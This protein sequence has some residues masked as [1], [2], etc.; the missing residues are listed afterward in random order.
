M[1]DIKFYFSELQNNFINYFFELLKEINDSNNYSKEEIEMICK[2]YKIASQAHGNTLR[3]SG[4]PYIIHPLNV[5]HILVQYGFDADTICAALLHDTVEDTSYTLDEI[6]NDFNETIS[7]LVDGVTKIKKLSKEEQEIFT[8]QKLLNSITKDA[9]VIAIKLA[10]RLHNMVTLEA[11]S[12]EKQQEN[13]RETRDFYVPLAR[14]LGIYKLKDEIQDLSLFFLDKP[15]FETYYELREK[16]KDKYLDEYEEIGIK[17][18]DTLAQRNIPLDYNFKVKNIG[19]IYSETNGEIVKKIEDIKIDDLVAIRMVLN[20]IGECYQALGVVHEFTK[21]IHH[22]FRDYISSPKQNGYKSLNTNVLTDRNS[23]FQVRIR[24]K[25]MQKRNALGMVFN[26]NDK[27]QKV[28]RDTFLELLQLDNITYEDKDKV[29]QLSKEFLDKPIEI[30]YNGIYDQIEK[31][32]SIFDFI[33]NNYIKLEDIDSIEVNGNLE[34]LD[35]EL[36]AND[37]LVIIKKLKRKGDKK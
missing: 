17:T 11:L 22:K 23:E 26:W 19:G 8:H 25:E 32:T 6:K 1:N 30:K 12:F 35:Y 15:A 36:N 37:E 27:G 29:E 18:A 31:N 16:I 24:T 9:R 2:A 7:F 20:E 4:E 5:A 14:R 33:K 10:D 3:S 13:A 28:I 21:P 34:E